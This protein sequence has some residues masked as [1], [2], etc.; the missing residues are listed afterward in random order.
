MLIFKL[1]CKCCIKCILKIIEFFDI[2]LIFCFHVVKIT[3]N[4]LADQ[5]KMEQRFGALLLIIIILKALCP[6]I[7]GC[8]LSRTLT[9]HSRKLNTLA[10][11]GNHDSATSS[12]SFKHA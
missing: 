4:L 12:V 9:R 10:F 8:P 7:M 11:I 5:S 1:Y 3:H 2:K 6:L